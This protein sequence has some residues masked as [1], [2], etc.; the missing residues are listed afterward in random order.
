MSKKTL[1]IGAAFCIAV[2][3]VVAGG[4]VFWYLPNNTCP[5]SCN[6]GNICTEDICSKATDYECKTQP[7]A[8]CCGNKIF[9]TTEK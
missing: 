2:I 8:N 3:L 5:A 6:D 1:F 7:I 4:Y 9:D